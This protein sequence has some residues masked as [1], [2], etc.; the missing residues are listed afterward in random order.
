[1]HSATVLLYV[2]APFFSTL[3]LKERIAPIKTIT[4]AME[5]TLWMVF[6]LRI[7]FLLTQLYVFSKIYIV[8]LMALLPHPKGLMALQRAKKYSTTI[9]SSRLSGSD[10]DRHSAGVGDSAAKQ[11]YGGICCLRQF[12]AAPLGVFEVL[13]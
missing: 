8:V 5:K 1:M 13:A 10:I 2:F 9:F 11:R 3:S 7:V 6:V 12:S 4:T